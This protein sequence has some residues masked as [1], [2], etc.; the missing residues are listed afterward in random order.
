MPLQG[1]VW[2][3]AVTYCQQAGTRAHDRAAFREAVASF[4]Q[5]LQALTHLLEHRDTRGLG[6][7]LRLALAR[8]LRALG[9]YGRHL[10][11]QGEAEALARALDDRAR[12][13]RVLAEMGRVLRLT[14]D[15]D[16][17]I[18]MGRQALDLAAALG[19]GALQVQASHHLGQAYYAIGDFVRAAELLRWNV[20]AADRASG[21][22]STEVRIEVVSL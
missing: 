16:G 5:A 2:D 17:A 14:G 8:P 12:L 9:E 1:E 10:A 4:E 18:V 22:P 19:D 15:H 3:K 21:T 11:Q 7:E 20:E 13:E 6:L